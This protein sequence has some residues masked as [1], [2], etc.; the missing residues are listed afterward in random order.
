MRGQHL[1]ASRPAPCPS[2]QL[3][4]HLCKSISHPTW[5][6]MGIPGPSPTRTL[7]LDLAGAEQ[8]QGW[9]GPGTLYSFQTR[10]PRS[11]L[12]ATSLAVWGEAEK[13]EGWEKS[14]QRVALC[15]DLGAVSARA[16]FQVCQVALGP[17]TGKNGLWLMRKQG[18]LSCHWPSH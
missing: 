9:T 16:C 1:E 13:S 15:I 4:Q 10:P 17:G 3:R 11:S 14:P 18:K 6:G 2:H 5:G 12:S 8:N 7:G